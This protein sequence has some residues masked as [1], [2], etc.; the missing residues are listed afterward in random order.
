VAA[1]QRPPPTRRRRKARPRTD[2]ESVELG[3]LRNPGSGNRWR[4][5]GRPSTVE[6]FELGRAG[7]AA[8]LDGLSGPQTRGTCTVLRLV[9]SPQ[10][11]DVMTPTTRTSYE[12]IALD[13]GGAP[14]IPNANTKVVELVAKVKAHG[15]SPEEL[16]FQLP[17]LTLGQIHSALA[18]YWDH[19]EEIDADLRRREQEIET[20]RGEVGD[21]P[22]IAKLRT[23]GQ[24]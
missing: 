19:L 24:I 1:Q 4:F 9:E 12:H 5:S 16:A 2:D 15:W 10:G 21:H 14:W 6:G 11:I 8:L 22:L 13:E 18:Y 3:R 7:S 17:H 20:I 23:R